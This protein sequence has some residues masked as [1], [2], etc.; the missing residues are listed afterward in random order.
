M[1]RVTRVP[2]R[3]TGYQEDSGVLEEILGYSKGSQGRSRESQVRL[4]DPRKFQGGFPEVSEAFQGVAG[5]YK[6]VSRDTRVF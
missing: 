4:R 3:S 2:E 6:G 5:G 1:L